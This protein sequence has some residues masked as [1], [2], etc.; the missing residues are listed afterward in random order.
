MNN[1]ADLFLPEAQVSVLC[2]V[3][4]RVCCRILKDKHGDDI[5]KDLKGLMALPG[6][7]IKMATIAM[8]VSACRVESQKLV[9]GGP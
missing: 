1:R 6:V 3:C 2:G 5:P 4:A 9:A 7:G 8:S